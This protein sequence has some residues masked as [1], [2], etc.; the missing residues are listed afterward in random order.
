MSK[1]S[2]SKSYESYEQAKHALLKRA[3]QYRH[4]FDNPVGEQVLA[5][6]YQEFCPPNLMGKTNAQTNANIGKREVV[7]Y[8]KAMMEYEDND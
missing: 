6:L 2:R 8:I 7:H 1:G 5:D 4:V 3:S